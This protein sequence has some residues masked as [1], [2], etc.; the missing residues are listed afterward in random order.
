MLLSKTTPRIESRFLFSKIINLL[1]N[2]MLHLIIRK[3]FYKCKTH[4]EKFDTFPESHVYYILRLGMHKC[5]FNSGQAKR[6]LVGLNCFTG[7][8]SIS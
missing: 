6:M 4:K 1:L 3:Y 5:A 7:S 2:Y 8:N